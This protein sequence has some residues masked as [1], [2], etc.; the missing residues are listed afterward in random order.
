M[1]SYVII[2]LL[3][4]VFMGVWH[5]RYECDSSVYVHVFDVG[6]GDAILVEIPSKKTILVDGGPGDYVLEEL[7]SSLPPWIRSIDTIVLTHPHADHLEGLLDVLERYGVE[8]IYLNP[9]CYDNRSYDYLLEEVYEIGIEVVVLG[10]LGYF[11]ESVSGVEIGYFSRYSI[12]CGVGVFSVAFKGGGCGECSLDL[13]NSSIVVVVS[14]VKGSVLLM[15]DAEV[16]VEVQLYQMIL[17]VMKCNKFE[18]L[19]AGHH[20]SRTASSDEFLDLV[21]P[22]VAI[23]S[24][25]R[26]NKFDHPH[27][28]TIDRFDSH[29][30]SYYR[31]DIDGTIT[32]EINSEGWRVML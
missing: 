28:E 18:V 12:E 23:C 1:K 6:Q 21:R 13:N 5:F 31:T 4:V 20:C 9:I 7:G 27:V 16:E 14:N 26:D 2:G 30:I 8:E 32:I 17:S 24:L 15:G 29:G 19:K 11:V 22:D 25:G 3:S 10:P